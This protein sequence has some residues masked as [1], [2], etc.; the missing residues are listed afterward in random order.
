MPLV[1]ICKKDNL[2]T[3]INNVMTFEK[4]TSKMVQDV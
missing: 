3:S 1:S 2:L 4:M